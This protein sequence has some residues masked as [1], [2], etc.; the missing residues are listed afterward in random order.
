MCVVLS[1]GSAGPGG[2]PAQKESAGRP[3]AAQRPG[4]HHQGGGVGAELGPEGRDAP[5]RG[6]ER[7]APGQPA[8][9]P[10]QSAHEGESRHDSGDSRLLLRFGD[11]R[12]RHVSPEK[13]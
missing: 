1:A 5:G 11:C 6:R 4:V 9:I 10:D 12:R 7:T 3:S 2:A 13:M 8:A